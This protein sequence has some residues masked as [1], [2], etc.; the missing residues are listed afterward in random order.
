MWW[1]NKFNLRDD[2][3]AL[4]RLWWPLL[5]HHFPK[6]EDF[7][8]KHIVPL[9]NRI[10]PTYS[11]EQ[12]EWFAFRND[13][14]IGQEIEQMAM[15]QYSAFYFICRS[16]LIINYEPHLYLEDAFLFLDL[17]IKN[18]RKF[19]QIWRNEL[20]TK[21]NLPRSSFPYHNRIFYAAF[22]NET[23]A[24]RDVVTHAPKIGKA[25]TLGPEFVP[26]Q[27]HLSMAEKSWRYV[28][29]LDDGSFV[30]GRK[31]VQRLLEDLLTVLKEDWCCIEQVLEPARTSAQYRLCFNLD[32]NYCIPGKGRSR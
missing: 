28:Q 1:E 31:L 32:N 18:G 17:A 10:D 26:E 24:Y 20:S 16:A 29:G 5:N 11:R 12:R 7:W 6:Y 22:A 2:G 14:N 15:A 21:I 9:T 19:L 4:E 8:R 30:D 13:A 25:L 3:D 23:R 27:T